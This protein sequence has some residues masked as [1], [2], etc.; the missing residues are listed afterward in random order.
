[1]PSFRQRQSDRHRKSRDKSESP[2]Q[3]TAR[4]IT[5]AAISSGIAAITAAIANWSGF[6]QA[7]RSAPLA[8]STATAIAAVLVSVNVVTL[9]KGMVRPSLRAILRIA[10]TAV[11]LAIYLI[12]VSQP[13]ICLF[14]CAPADWHPF[15][16]DIVI[17]TAHAE[18]IA[19]FEVLDVAIDDEH[20]TFLLLTDNSSI[21]GSREEK[22]RLSVVFDR[23]MNEVFNSATCTGVDGETPIQD[24][25]PVWRT[26]LQT[27]GATD[28]V[29]RLQDYAGY[30]RLIQTGG[31]NTFN[32]A[33]PNRAELLELSKLQPASYNII[34]H[35]MAKCVGISDPVLIWTL[36]NNTDKT[37]VISEI[38]D[39]VIEVG[40]VKGGGPDTIDPVDIPPH[41]LEHRVGIQRHKLTSLIP[42]GSHQVVPL[43]IK[44]V[45]PTDD[46][47]YTWLMRP[48]FRTTN[49]TVIA[50]PEVKIFSAKNRH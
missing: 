18:P 47:G 25:L 50:G 29:S 30:R 20:S 1:M 43:K 23:N 38:D 3:L 22:S 41:P 35:W 21:Q 14:G 44:Y 19:P 5:L 27:R 34:L 48:V 12:Y 4:T 16:V 17:S 24:A 49:G 7:M 45:L 32:D 15:K 42:I 10:A 39:D 40:Q 26:I 31:R 36:Q 8:T 6:V 37:V 9:A 13:P 2:R 28:L 11:V 46:W 33:R